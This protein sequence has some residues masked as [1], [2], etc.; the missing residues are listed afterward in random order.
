MLDLEAEG[1]APV[2]TPNLLYVFGPVVPSFC[3]SFSASVKGG[4]ESLPQGA[5]S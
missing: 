5:C 2:F 4:S 3:A 1:L